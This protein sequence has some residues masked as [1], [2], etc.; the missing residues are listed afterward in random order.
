MKF[1]TAVALLSV[2]VFPACGGDD[3]LGAG[4]SQETGVLVTDEKLCAL[5]IRMTTPA[6][7]QELLG[8]ADRSSGSGTVLILTYH[9]R[10]MRAAVVERERAVT[11]TFFDE[12]E[13]PGNKV[14]SD[15]SL[16]DQPAAPPPDCLTQ[17]EPVDP[18]A[19]D[20]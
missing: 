14:L 2:A 9:Y 10:K 11:L 3:G 5:S 18:E 15:I 16:L 19:P 20:A 13:N 1:K 7:A 8:T 6:A 12:F 4:G 17:V